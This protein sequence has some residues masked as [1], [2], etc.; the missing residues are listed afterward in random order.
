MSLTIQGNWTVRVLYKQPQSLPQRFIISGA[1]SGNGTY[2]S[3][4]TFPIFVTGQNW[5]IKIQAA[6]DYD[7]PYSWFDSN[8]R[9]TA[10]QQSGPTE[11][12]FD[13]ESEDYVQDNSWNDLI[14]RLTQ[15]VTIVPPPPPPPPPIIISDP[16]PTPPP[17]PIIISDPGPIIEPP[18]NP[19]PRPSGPPVTPPPPPPAPVILSPGKVYT[20]IP[21]EDQLPRQKILET[22]G[23]WVSSSGIPTGNLTTFHTCSAEVTPSFKRTIYQTECSQ[24]YAEP[25]F[26]I[27]YGHD[28]GSGSRDLGG[29][30]WTTPSNAIYGQYRGLCLETERRFSLGNKEIHHFYAI[31]VPNERMDD[32]LDEGNIELNLALLSGSAFIAG[33]GTVNAHTG[34]NVKLLGNGQVLRLIDDSRLDFT[35]DLVQ[36][37]YDNEYR[38]VSS[39]RAHRPNV[40]YM[41][42]GSIE[43]GI[44]NKTQPQVYGLLYPKLGVILL[45]ADKLDQSASFLTVTGSDVA[46]DNSMKLF[47]AISGAAQYTDAS[48]DVLGFQARKTKYSFVESYFIRVKNQDYNFTNNPT[49][50]TGSEGQIIE[51]FY[52]NPKVYLTEIGLYNPNHELL[53]VAKLSRPVLKNYQEEGLF[54]VKLKW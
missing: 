3:D 1:T 29:Y 44:Y 18:Y 4:D 50:Q 12:F 37:A 48:G 11:Q 21:D 28:G 19:P 20:L 8:M 30:D 17:P 49:Y 33:G 16:G 36:A 5:Q 32:K 9:R 25:Q 23:I 35:K 43:D 24:C 39:S 51:D 10:T 2:S 6:N 46:G 15:P 34:S 7:P 38:V 53:A 42:S 27:S 41:V 31:N 47:T 40:F 13:I 26:D 52:G 54:E 45:D 14:L 22:F